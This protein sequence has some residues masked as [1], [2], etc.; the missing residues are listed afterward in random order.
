MNQISGTVAVHV[1][2]VYEDCP[3]SIQ[4]CNMKNRDIYWRRYKKPETLYIGQW[5]LSPHIVFPIAISC[6]VI[7]SWISS[8]AWNLFPF[9]GDFSFGKSQKSQGAKSGLY[10]VWVTWVIW[11]FAK[12]LC[13][14]CERVCCCDEAANH[15]LPI[16]VVFW[17]IWILSVEEW[18][19]KLNAKFGADLLLYSDLNAMATQHMCSL[20]GVYCPHWLA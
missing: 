16:A 15:Q 4:P 7:F 13:P 8:M 19:F 5:C 14:R 11:C 2:K 1:S 6:S 18:M 9:K 3:E 12:K 17:I 20:K 10:G